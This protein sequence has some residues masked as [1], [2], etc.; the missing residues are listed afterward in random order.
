MLVQSLQSM[1]RDC[2]DGLLEERF[3]RGTSRAE[4][5]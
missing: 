2:A 4:L 5:D 1:F 3:D